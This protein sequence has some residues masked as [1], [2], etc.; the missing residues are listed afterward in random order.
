MNKAYASCYAAAAVVG[1]SSNIVDDSSTATC[2]SDT[3]QTTTTI[4]S[5]ANQKIALEGV[6][7][8]RAKAALSSQPMRLRSSRTGRCQSSRL[9]PPPPT[10]QPQASSKPVCVVGGALSTYMEHSYASIIASEFPPK[11]KLFLKKQ[12]SPAISSPQYNE[13]SP[14][15]ANLNEGLSLEEMGVC[16]AFSMHVCSPSSLSQSGFGFS[17]T[18][19]AVSL[20]W[21]GVYCTDSDIVVPVPTMDNGNTKEYS[22]TD[23]FSVRENQENQT[24]GN[25]GPSEVK[26]A[27]EYSSYSYIAPEQIRQNLESSIAGTDSIVAS[28]C[29]PVKQLDSKAAPKTV[30]CVMESVIPVMKTVENSGDGKILPKS[31]PVKHV[32]G[33]TV[34][35]NI[36]ATSGRQ[37]IKNNCDTVNDVEFISSNELITKGDDQFLPEEKGQKDVNNNEILSMPSSGCE[38][39]RKLSDIKRRRIKRP[40]VCFCD[41]NCNRSNTDKNIRV[42]P[43]K[44]TVGKC[45][46]LRSV[47]PPYHSCTSRVNDSLSPVTGALT[48]S[49]YSH[50]NGVACLS[51]GIPPN[52]N[53]KLVE[54]PV[55][56]FSSQSHKA[57]SHSMTLSSSVF[58]SV[59]VCSPVVLV[60]C[61]CHDPR[62]CASAQRLLDHNQ[63]PKSSICPEPLE[64]EL[65]RLQK[66]Q[67][68]YP[69]TSVIPHSDVCALNVPAT[70]SSKSD[71]FLSDQTPCNI[72]RSSNA[73]V[74][75]S[76]SAHQSI[77]QPVLLSTEPH[78]QMHTYS[79]S[80]AT[81][82]SSLA[83][84]FNFESRRIS[85]SR[86]TQSESLQN[87]SLISA[88]PNPEISTLLADP[89]VK[90][91]PQTPV[92]LSPKPGKSEAQSHPKV[93]PFNVAISSEGQKFHCSSF[94]TPPAIYMPPSLKVSQCSIKDARS[95][96][97]Y[98]HLYRPPLPVWPSYPHQH[99]HPYRPVLSP[100]PP[101]IMSVR[102]FSLKH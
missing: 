36:A 98:S 48:M 87:R 66:P 32:T 97:I 60:G 57:P 56:S 37:C 68:V 2:M 23:V 65:K 42:K 45:K 70:A 44:K 83:P 54:V 91:S 27:D 51:R 26:Q 30:R 62:L 22:I 18:F 10:P 31:K 74:L 39:K 72:S 11:I 38:N 89:S 73:I 96:D 79:I 43:I 25:I 7:A 17:S 95:T 52:L 9:A 16:A 76:L 80:K 41:K 46:R 28:S 6:V 24:D 59:H 85:T 88:K 63:P 92:L 50:I 29:S 67:S 78:S 20:S 101:P 47:C 1:P 69:T 81:S 34:N 102:P 8:S 12:P 86:K 84:T 93:L 21:C 33:I 5:S 64:A 14:S 40:K 4:A 61:R 82:S 15:T 55:S 35:S 71:Q 49:I 53:S 75:T 13:P 100:I 90:S 94:P 99:P 19:S 3:G 58:P 77:P